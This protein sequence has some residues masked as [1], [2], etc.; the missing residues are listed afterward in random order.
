MGYKCRMNDVTDL[1]RPGY[2][3]N[4]Q[5]VVRRPGMWPSSLI[6]REAGQ[7]VSDVRYW[8]HI[9]YKILWRIQKHFQE[10]PFRLRFP[11]LTSQNTYCAISGLLDIFSGHRAIDSDNAITKDRPGLKRTTKLNAT[12]VDVDVTSSLHHIWIRTLY[13]ILLL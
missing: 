1:W 3:Y 8:R 2:F 10:K 12:T 6:R 7:Y 9:T 5:L 11:P 4:T 13:T